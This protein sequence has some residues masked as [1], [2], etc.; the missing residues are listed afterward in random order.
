MTLA[1]FVRS[2]TEQAVAERDYRTSGARRS[3]LRLKQADMQLVGRPQIPSMSA[4]AS[5]GAKSSS[6]LGT[7]NPGEK[8]AWRA[9][10]RGLDLEF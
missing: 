2:Y 4:S 9:A 8:E 7:W 10:L 6:A 5:C 1:M 3:R